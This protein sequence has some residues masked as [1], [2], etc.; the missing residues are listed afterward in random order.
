ML[1]GKR[2]TLADGNRLMVV[3]AAPPAMV[4]ADVPGMRNTPSRICRRPS[5]WRTPCASRGSST[6][7]RNAVTEQSQR[8]Q[9]PPH[10]ETT[11]TRWLLAL[12]VAG[13]SAKRNV[14]PRCYSARSWRRSHGNAKGSVKSRPRN[15]RRASGWTS[16]SK[17]KRPLGRRRRRRRDGKRKKNRPRKLQPKRLGKL[18]SPHGF[19]R[20]ASNFHLSPRQMRRAVSRSAFAYLTA[21]D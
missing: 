9:D 21:G 19:K 1:R 15:T 13:N 12:P 10:N 14:W 11:T 20:H 7:R 4:H 18:P 5:R 3:P 2:P 17:R 6:S 16:K 8:Q